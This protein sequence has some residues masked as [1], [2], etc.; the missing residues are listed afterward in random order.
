MIV[1]L[2]AA[3]VGGAPVGASADATDLI[4]AQFKPLA[5]A[6]RSFAP[7]GPAGPFY[8]QAAA[9]GRQSGEASLECLTGK[10]GAL[11]RCKILSEAPRGFSF[12]AAAKV[13]ADRKRIFV[14]AAPPGQTVRVRV[15]FA[16]GAPAQMEP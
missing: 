4:E 3:I 16:I 10:D 8:P 11:T 6:E 15:P 9:M 2:L 7:L 14:Q 13:M 1:L 5:R 12:G